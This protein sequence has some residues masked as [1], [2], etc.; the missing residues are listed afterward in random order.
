MAK[1]AGLDMPKTALLQGEKGKT[2]TR[3]HLLALAEKHKIKNVQEIIKSVKASV[4]RWRSFAKEAGVSARE[5]GVIDKYLS[6]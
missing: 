2:P 6:I 5:I 4:N 3:K 1:D